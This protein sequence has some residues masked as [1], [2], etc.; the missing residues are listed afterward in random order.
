MREHPPD[1]TGQWRDVF[2]TCLGPPC[3]LAKLTR[4]DLYI[5][6]FHDWAD[7]LGQGAHILKPFMGMNV[8]C[9]FFTTFGYQR[10]A[11]A[12][13]SEKCLPRCP[14]LR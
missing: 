11:D 2:A 6:R 4:D 7:H 13:G 9:P 5:C 3:Q 1:F 14:R 10:I 8:S 12:G